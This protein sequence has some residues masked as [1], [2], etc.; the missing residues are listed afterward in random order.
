MQGNYLPCICACTA[1]VIWYTILDKV[2]L[3]TGFGVFQ[4]A[5]FRG[6]KLSGVIA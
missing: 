5:L 1:N 3:T 2:V 6:V 4:G